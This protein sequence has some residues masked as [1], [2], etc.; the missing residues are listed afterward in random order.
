MDSYERY[1]RQLPVIPEVATKIVRIAEDKID[2]SF[3]ELEN[4]IKVDPGLTAK[5]LKVANSALYARQREIKSLQM[6]IT[7]LGFKNIKSLVLLVSAAGLFPKYR[8]TPFYGRFWGH[9]IRTAFMSKH[10]VLRSNQKEMA[11]ETF[12]GGLLH[13][14]G[15]IAFLNADHEGY[16]KVVADAAAQQVPL[17]DFEKSV[18]GIHHRELGAS[19]LQKWYFPDLYVDVAREHAS[20]NITSSHK[21]MIVVVSVADFITRLMG[22][23]IEAPEA[24]GMFPRL[25]AQADLTERD[26]EYYQ[27]TYLEDLKGDTFFQECQSLFSLS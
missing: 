9:S 25:A 22:Y 24:E 8:K 18:Y 21:R 27:N 12:L 1:L 23:G 4:I 19:V 16:Q 2:V 10:M 14:V 7:L 13:D 20:L 26:V 3:K 17:E 6:A 11:E 5:I 15:Q